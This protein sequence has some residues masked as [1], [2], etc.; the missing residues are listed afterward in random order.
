M[1]FSIVETFSAKVVASSP[2]EAVALARRSFMRGD[3]D[4]AEKTCSDGTVEVVV[5][6]NQTQRHP[7]FK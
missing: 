7:L 3:Y 2:D 5:S 4:S 1:R 6:E